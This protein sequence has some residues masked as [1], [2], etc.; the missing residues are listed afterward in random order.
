MY[1]PFLNNNFKKTCQRP[2]KRCEFSNMKFTQREQ[3]GTFIIIYMPEMPT[4]RMQAHSV[5]KRSEEFYA[6]WTF[7]DLL[8]AERLRIQDKMVFR[9]R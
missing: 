7:Y 4:N 9:S 8:S 6:V 5:V 3:N 2:S 1:L